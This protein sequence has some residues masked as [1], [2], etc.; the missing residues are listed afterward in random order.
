M[1]S[2][3][4]ITSVSSSVE[5]NMEITIDRTYTQPSF[6]LILYEFHVYKDIWSS[7]TGEE[8][9]CKHEDQNKHNKFALAIY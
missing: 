3:E 8:L 5:D 2:S 6:D 4:L 9:N 1:D 7:L